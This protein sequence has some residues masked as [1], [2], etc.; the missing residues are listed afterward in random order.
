MDKFTDKPEKQEWKRYLKPIAEHINNINDLLSR[1]DKFTNENFLEQINLYTDNII[2]DFSLIKKI[3]KNDTTKTLP[4]LID[5]LDNLLK[6]FSLKRFYNL[7]P[8]ISYEDYT[9]LPI[10]EQILNNVFDG[11]ISATWPCLIK[12]KYVR[13]GNCYHW[14]IAIK[15]IFDKLALKWVDCKINKIPE[16]E[17]HAFVVIESSSDIYMFDM[18]EYWKSLDAKEMMKV[19]NLNA[20]KVLDP[21]HS[22]LMEFNNVYKFAGNIDKNQYNSIKLQIDR[23]KVEIIDRKI[24]IEITKWNK[25]IKRTFNIMLEE[26]NVYTKKELLEKMFPWISSIIPIVSNKIMKERLLNVINNTIK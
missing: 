23:I 26:N 22:D 3:Y 7:T 12:K 11:N 14:A 19:G 4:I 24:A 18:V 13:G 6:I 17:G 2:E 21:Y 25:V 8:N 5:F 10:G 20:H 9:N 1:Y 16:I 15:N